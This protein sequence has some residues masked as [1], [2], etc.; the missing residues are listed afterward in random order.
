M[1][2][3]VEEHL[4][5]VVRFLECWYDMID[6]HRVHCT[7]I[8]NRLKFYAIESIVIRVDPYTSYG[9]SLSVPRNWGKYSS[10]N[11]GQIAIHLETCCHASVH[12]KAVII[13]NLVCRRYDQ[14]EQQ[15]SG[16]S[17][18]WIKF[19]NP[20]AAPLFVGCRNHSRLGTS[21]WCWKLYVY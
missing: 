12:V 1:G 17:L 13:N 20:A 19:T 18:E 6:P 2:T 10:T 15:L 8:T 21:L 3:Y 11:N 4:F 16:L 9:K 5:G 14:W 7:A